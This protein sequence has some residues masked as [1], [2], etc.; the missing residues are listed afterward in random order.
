MNSFAAFH[1]Y[2]PHARVFRAFNSI[3]WENFANPA[4]EGGTADLF[5]CGPNDDTRRIVEQL[6]SAIGLRPMYLGGEEQVGLVDA[7][8]GLSFAL[9]FGQ[10][11]GRHL[12]FK[13]LTR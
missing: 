11:M 10:G 2:T 12:A 8:A 1:Q 3:S 4:F 6:I 13:V 9:A 7:V 5:Y